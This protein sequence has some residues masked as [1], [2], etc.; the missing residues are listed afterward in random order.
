M[1]VISALIFV[2]MCTPSLA[3]QDSV[4][5]GKIGFKDQLK[6]AARAYFLEPR[7]HLIKSI[8]R[9]DSLLRLDSTNLGALDE[10]I[11]VNMRSGRS[12]LAWEDFQRLSGL[13]E[14]IP[15]LYFYRASNLEYFGLNKSASTLYDKHLEFLQ[16]T[17]DTS[18]TSKE[19]A[20]ALL[21]TWYIY[22]YLGYESKADSLVDVLY[23]RYD[24]WISVGV[25]SE[26]FSKRF[27]SSV[28]EFLEKKEK[29]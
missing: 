26:F 15:E 22:Q 8:E 7:P 23:E 1:R 20:N 10:R 14:N 18:I 11:T 16:H 29:Q 6:R 3:A 2:C 24:E 21:S 5:T 9:I 25:G 4:Q 19:K 12:D 13:A 28:F 27:G 17:F